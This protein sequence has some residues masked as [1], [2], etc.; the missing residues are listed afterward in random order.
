MTFNYSVYFYQETHL[1]TNASL[2]I[3]INY[4]SN[5]SCM[6]VCLSV[7]VSGQEATVIYSGVKR[8][9]PKWASR[10]GHSLP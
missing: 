3:F 9:C 2:V 10:D 4:Y 6:Y 8:P 5:Y 1:A 7:V